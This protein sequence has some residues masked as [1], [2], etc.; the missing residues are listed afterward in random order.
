MRD[1][2]DAAD[3]MTTA[4]EALLRDLLPALS[5]ERRYAALMIANGMAIAAREHRLGTDAS[6]N[7][8][9]R[10]R[11]LLAL[12]PRDAA[13]SSG[14]LPTSDVPALRKVICA[15]IRAGRFDAHESAVGSAL[16]HTAAAWS[17]AA[18]TLAA[19]VTSSATDSTLT[20]W[21]ISESCTGPSDSTRRAAIA[22]FAPAAASVSA[23]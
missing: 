6:R 19:S 15:A 9:A 11:N 12:F 1:I 10:L 22:T 14:D 16:A 17:N 21:R 23:K 8:A 18:A 13:E 2:S 5:G 3:L 4:R 20:P 7:E